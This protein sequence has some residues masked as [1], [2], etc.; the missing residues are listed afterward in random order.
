MSATKEG[1]ALSPEQQVKMCKSKRRFK[2]E[3]QAITAAAEW[4]AKGVFLGGRVYRCPVC[5]GHH[6]TTGAKKL[7]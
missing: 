2:K 5:N 7:D 1:D 4:A 6:V 3:G